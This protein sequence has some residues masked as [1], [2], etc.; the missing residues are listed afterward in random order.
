MTIAGE[1]RAPARRHLLELADLSGIS[2][3]EAREILDRV[4]SAVA[5]WRAHARSAEVGLKTIRVIEK[6]IQDG[7]ARL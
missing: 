2:S 4:A 1:G 6:A 3:R 7:L 5:H